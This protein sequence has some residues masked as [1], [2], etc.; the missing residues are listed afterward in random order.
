MSRRAESQGEPQ[1]VIR[2]D[3]DREVD[4]VISHLF[5]AVY[6]SPEHRGAYEQ[7]F[8]LRASAVMAFALGVM[9]C[10]GE[11]WVRKPRR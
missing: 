8:E 4:H 3:H 7:E 9:R 5:D 2:A 6:N 10:T 11:L 1:W